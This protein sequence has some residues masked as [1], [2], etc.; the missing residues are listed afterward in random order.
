MSK[1]SMMLSILWLLKSGRRITAKEIAD[2]LEIN[3]R[4][5]YRYIDSLCASGVPIIADSGHNG[6]YSLLHDFT[7]A[8]L[9]FEIDEQKALNHAAI[10]A[11]ES[12]Y[13]YSEV[14][15]RAISK[16]NR[17]TNETQQSL[18]NRH[19]Q[20]FD[21]IQ[22]PADPSLEATLQTLEA[23]VA[24]GITLFMS[25]EKG[26]VNTI[27]ERNIDPYGLVHWK[28]RWYIVGY[29]HLRDEVRSFRVDRIINLK[30]TELTF[31]RPANFSVRSFF[32]KSLLPDS[33]AKDTFITVKIQAHPQ[34]IK[35]LSSHW[36]LWPAFI[37]GTETEAHFKLKKDIALFYLPYSLLPYGR[38]IQILEPKEVKEQ[39]VTVI[40][41]LLEHYQKI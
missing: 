6:G 10:Y 31:N 29:C 21:V 27:S 33:D 2:S 19:T 32:L 12:G 4:T 37:E 38:A 14:L 17:Y 28:N 36:S 20:G 5:V 1:S 11:Q 39:M 13:P 34:V 30:Q 9:F 40:K 25:Y 7:E 15:N 18:I 24:K 8:P 16:L 41:N 26:H 22:P 35:E 23:A 3:I